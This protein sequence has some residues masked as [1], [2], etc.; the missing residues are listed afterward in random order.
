MR[1]KFHSKRQLSGTV[2]EFF[3]ALEKPLEY[4]AGQYVD[5]ALHDVMNDPRGN[6]RTFTLTSIPDDD[7][8][9]FAT[10]FPD[11]LSPFKKSLLQLGV[12]DEVVI[13]QAMGDMVLPRH[14]D[15]P[16]FFV[17]GGL[18]VASFIPLLRECARTD[19]AHPVVLLWALRYTD[20]APSF[21]ILD[22]F[23]FADKQIY[24]QPN[25]LDVADLI[26]SS[27]NKPLVYVSGSQKFTESIVAELRNAGL[28]DSHLLFDYFTGYI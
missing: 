13:S 9:S 18:G 23:N 28:T 1:V 27:N 21:D 16:L 26:T 12:D 4:A 20:D 7:F 14:H 6:T 2:W 3:F 15:T 24:I 10:F 19:L 5:V 22:S 11:E 17:A 8:I 25:R